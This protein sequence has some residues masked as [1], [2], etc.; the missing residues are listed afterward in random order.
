[1]EGNLSNNQKI[2]QER[3][4]SEDETKLNFL[5]LSKFCLYTLLNLNM[6]TGNDLNEVLNNSLN[7]IRDMDYNKLES[8]MREI[9]M[10][11]NNRDLIHFVRFGSELGMRE[12]CLSFF[13]DIEKNENIDVVKYYNDHK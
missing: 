6:K 2:I 9:L 13:L 8:F 4:I 7:A 3:I 1:M 10:E 5:Q 11:V 12:K